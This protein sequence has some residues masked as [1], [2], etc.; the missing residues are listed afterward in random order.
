MDVIIDHRCGNNFSVGGAKI[1]RLW[2]GKQ[3]LVDNQIQCVFFEKRYTQCT[4]GSHAYVSD[5]FP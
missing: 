5:A 1:E 2:L 3:K 4:M